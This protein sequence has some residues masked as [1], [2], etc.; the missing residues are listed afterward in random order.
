MEEVLNLGC[1]RRRVEGAVNVDLTARTGPDVVHDLN[2][3]PWPLPAD[4]FREVWARDVIEHLED[5]FGIFEEIH[6]VARAGAKVH[7]T[8]PHFSSAD[9]YSDPTHRRFF[10]RASLDFLDGSHE[11]SFYTAARFRERAAR[12]IF[13]PTLTN[14]LVSR[15][16][17]RRP[18]A[19]ERRWA[20]TFPAW[21]I[22]FEL[23]VLK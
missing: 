22:Y 4:H 21:F 19:Y 12:I 8:V 5:T 15:L 2:V 13:R 6:R 16:A 1:G 17:N 11:N 23:E 18:A 3:R 10:G 14:R 9:A 20:W 7:V